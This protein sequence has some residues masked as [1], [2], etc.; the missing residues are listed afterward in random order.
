MMGPNYSF[1]QTSS[2]YHHFGPLVSYQYV[3]S[4]QNNIHI[5]R[6]TPKEKIGRL[7]WLQYSTVWEWLLQQQ[8]GKVSQRWSSVAGLRSP[9]FLALLTKLVSQEMSLILFFYNMRFKSLVVQTIHNNKHDK[10]ISCLWKETVRLVSFHI[11]L[12]ETSFS[13]FSDLKTC[14]IWRALLLLL[15][16][17]ELF[18]SI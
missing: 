3:C 14:F 10:N 13:L 11:H 4:Y 7:Q 15:V 2:S 6:R 18:V 17:L 8:P 5:S 9:I 16:I 12:L 1:L